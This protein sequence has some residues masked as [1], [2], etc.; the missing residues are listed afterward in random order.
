MHCDTSDFGYFSTA[1]MPV[2]LAALNVR[3]SSGTS[4]V[5]R[6]PS[7][8]SASEIGSSLGWP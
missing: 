7:A 2:L 6:S 8:C 4:A 3:E 5:S 1:G